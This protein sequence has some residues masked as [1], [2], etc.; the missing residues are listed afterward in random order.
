[1]TGMGDGSKT[2]RQ[3]LGLAVDLV[4]ISVA[5]SLDGH[6]DDRT[7]ERLVLSSPE[8]CREVHELRAAADAILVGAGTVRRDDPRLTVRHPDL[9]AR[10]RAEGR[11]DQPAKI[12]LTGRGDL[13]PDGT[14]FHDGGPRLVLCPEGEVARLRGRLGRHADIVGLAQPGPHG[15]LEALAARGVRNLLIEGGSGVLALF[16]QAGLFHRLRVAVAPFFIGDP[17]APRFALPGVYRNDKQTPLRLVA[18]RQ[19][20]GV[21]VM[22]FVNDLPGGETP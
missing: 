14:F 15:A 8:D 1:M 5:M 20:G 7:D 12:V 19:P 10:R 3:P 2:G 9:V 17:T 18:T 16:L 22:D 4:Q 11:P 13:S 21:A 6:I